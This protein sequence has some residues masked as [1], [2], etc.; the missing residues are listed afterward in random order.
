MAAQPEAKLE[1][2]AAET[3]PHN[4]QATITRTTFIIIALDSPRREWNT[5]ARIIVTASPA[6][7]AARGREPHR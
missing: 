3:S 5:A 4:D 7:P 6:A 2:V 1:R